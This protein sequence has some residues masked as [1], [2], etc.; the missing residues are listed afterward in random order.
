MNKKNIIILLIIILVIAGFVCFNR[1]IDKIDY[2]AGTNLQTEKINIK[3]NIPLTGAL[4]TYGESIRDGVL[5]FESNESKFVKDFNYDLTID[6]NQSDAK[7]ANSIY[8]QHSIGNMNIYVS[9]VKPQTMTILDEVSK[10]KIPH[11][12]WVFDYDI[13]KL[14]ESVYRT[15]VSYSVEPD[16]YFKYIKKRNAK[17]VAIA[18]VKLPHTDQEFKEIIAPY[19]NDNNIDFIMESYDYGKK[20]FKDLAAKFRDFGPDL[21]I[22]NGFKGELISMV[23]YFKEINLSNSEG[24]TICTYDFI[25]ASENLTDEI[26]EG[27]RFV[28]PDFFAN[29]SD[30]KNVW[31]EKFLE[32]M[33]RYPRYTDAY[34]YDMFHSILLASQNVSNK[35]DLTEWDNA[36]RN[37]NFNGITGNIKFDETG[38]LEPSL[39]VLYF[40]DGKIKKEID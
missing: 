12:A 4:A 8:K 18:Y 28:S 5:F 17:K 32:K 15:W 7:M 14:N 13:T 19:L 16:Y 11:F 27:I 25:D 34:A 26:K 24:N 3:M 23:K 29:K 20:D 30:K 36:F 6:D 35:N 2:V 40:Q 39:D 10:K 21:L 33:K 38:D 31:T 1:K 37:L 9:G 22:L